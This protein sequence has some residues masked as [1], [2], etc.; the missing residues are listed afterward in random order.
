MFRIIFWG[1][2]Q[3]Q[4][5]QQKRTTTFILNTFLSQLLAS[6]G[7]NLHYFFPQRELA[8]NLADEIIF[9][10]TYNMCIWG[11]EAVELEEMERIKAAFSIISRDISFQFL[12]ECWGYEAIFGLHEYYPWNLTRE[13]SVHTNCQKSILVNHKT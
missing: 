5:Q 2:K 6:P 8:L 4:Q 12:N 3:Q 10:S 13:N 11:F 9:K 1:G 7:T